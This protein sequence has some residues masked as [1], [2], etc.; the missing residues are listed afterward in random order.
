ME[1][2]VPGGQ[3]TDCLNDELLH[4]EAIRFDTNAHANPTDRDSKQ[5]SLTRCVDHTNETEVKSKKFLK[6]KNHHMDTVKKTKTS[7]PLSFATIM[8]G[9]KKISSF[10]NNSPKPVKKSSKGLN[11]TKSFNKKTNENNNEQEPKKI[12]GGIVCF[13]GDRVPGLVGLKNHG[14]TCF[15]NAVLQCLSNT[16][17][18][19]EYF[20]TD[21]YKQDIRGKSKYNAK[22]YG[23]KGELTQNLAR[24]I[25]SLWL[26][27]YSP[28]VSSDLKAIVGKY[29]PQYR[30]YSQHDAQEFLLW[31]LDKL[32][33]DLNIA[34]KKKFVP[35]KV[36]KCC[37]TFY[38]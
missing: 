35:S 38:Q 16:E 31:L 11:R 5:G 32:H 6:S 21:Q 12:T 24:L 13:E 27:Q 9:V 30:G 10:S 36:S 14:N 1:G 15:M 7:N 29:G 19:T 3:N 37:T 2:R 8:K 22:K 23:T 34:P 17:L 18:L 20:V 25:K 28:A 33:E 4:S 26:R